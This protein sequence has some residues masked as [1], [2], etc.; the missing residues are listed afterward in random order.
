M[1]TGNFSILSRYSEL[2]S[3]LSELKTNPKIALLDAIVWLVTFLAYLYPL[4]AFSVLRP[5]LII[6]NI[7]FLIRLAVFIDKTIRPPTEILLT[8]FFLLAFCDTLII[9]SCLTNTI[10]Y[11]AFFPKIIHLLLV[12]FLALIFSLILVTNSK[13]KGGVLIVAFLICI[14]ALE[15]LG[16]Q[17]FFLLIALQV[18]LFL[19]LLKKTSWLEELTKAELYISL[20]LLYFVFT[21][22]TN[23]NIYAFQSEPFSELTL[24]Y[25]WPRLL[26]IAFKIYL[27]VLFL[28]IPIVLIY[29]F[30]SLS[31]KLRIS[32]IFQST[33]PQ[34]IQLSLLLLIFYAFLA[35][36]QA[37]KTRK[38]IWTTFDKI[39]S[40]EVKSAVFNRSLQALRSRSIQIPGYKPFFLPEDRS[41]QGIIQLDILPGYKSSNFFLFR[42]AENDAGESEITYIK[43]DS[44]FMQ[45][46]SE[47]TFV[48]AGTHLLGYPYNPGKVENYF[49]RLI[50]KMPVHL[51]ERNDKNF[52]IFPFG[53]IPDEHEWVLQAALK[54][55]G[56]EPDQEIGD[57]ITSNLSAGRLI[58]PILDTSFNN[59]GFFVFDVLFVPSLGL[60]TSTLSSYVLLLIILFFLIN[61]VVTK[62]MITFGAEINKMIVQKFGQ[63]K[64]GIRE[65]SMGNLDYKVKVEGRDEFV[66]LAGH[67]NQMG[68]KLKESIADAREKERLAHELTIAKKVQLDLLPKKLPNVPGFQVAAILETANEVGGDFY[69]VI[70]LDK[71][72]FLFTIG[73]VSGKGTSAAFY[74]AQCISLIR[75]S[76]QFT[77]EP[78]KIAVKLNEYFSGSF[79]DK[80][81]F[82]TA[83]LGVIDVK[84]ETITFVRAGHTKPILVKADKETD[85]V[86]LS[87]NGIGLGI[88]KNQ[89]EFT[90]AL[91]V[92][93]QKFQAGDIMVFYTDGI[94]E[95]A[96]GKQ[97][98]GEEVSY[99]SIE[100]LKGKLS[101]SRSMTSK[102][103][104]DVIKA[105]I[106]SFYCDAS[107][108]DD[109]TLLVIKKT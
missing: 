84:K 20:P 36:W 23:L 73:D 33:L 72:R 9:K 5:F 29:N 27:V 25:A 106:K 91:E 42:E 80:Q 104:V 60:F 38:A 15:V 76:P 2:W 87:Q 70:E 52:Y 43:I 69:D 63:L 85:V 105:D 75:Y 88:Q 64:D 19:Y 24:W 102:K 48:L 94:E 12:S 61:T 99:Y 13:G 32:G 35:G 4:D 14:P 98:V 37:E 74:M 34:L 68:D 40:G 82:V 21:G 46:C 71:N 100:R 78:E 41:D 66:E 53:L 49:Y 47:N 51:G 90:K 65:I 55:Y 11:P 103:I 77:D 31:R 26:H 45:I 8:L 108:V 28:K 17:H 7:Y 10:L 58:T 54:E 83:I 18:A 22:F 56:Q 44:A 1:S 101:D 86:E 39:T 50:T 96:V 16:S 59:S 62:R 6:V 107:Q 97:G 3:R 67:F 95:A 57:Q 30:A 79:I 81:I 109:Y 92:R 89:D 93:T